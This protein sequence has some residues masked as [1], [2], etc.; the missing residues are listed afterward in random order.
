VEALTSTKTRV[1]GGTAKVIRAAAP[2]WPIVAVT[3]GPPGEIPVFWSK[4]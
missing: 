4:S 3:V 2:G 1:P